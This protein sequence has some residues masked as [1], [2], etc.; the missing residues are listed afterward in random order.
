[1]R[2]LRMNRLNSHKHFLHVLKNA[3]PK[4]RKA[5]LQTAD[6]DL[7]KALLECV[8]NTLNGNHKVTPKVKSKLC[9]FKNCFR[10]LAN[11]K[12]S[13]KKKRKLLIQKGG[14]LIPLLTSILSG[15]V[16]RLIAK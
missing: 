10:K 14:F 9:K 13:L 4:A 3:T 6:D 8:I 7:I 15:L 16:G 5:I 11:P 1:M 2:L 12:V